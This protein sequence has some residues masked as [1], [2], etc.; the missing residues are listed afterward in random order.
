MRVLQH[1]LLT[2]KVTEQAEKGVYGFVVA[3]GA[4]KLQIRKAVEDMYGVNVV[5]VRTSRTPGK[6]KSRFT[7]KGFTQ[8][9]VSGYKK[10]LVQVAEGEMIDLYENL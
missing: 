7:K 10:A 8:G 2:E 4:N 1:A 9:R 6:P 3:E 5:S